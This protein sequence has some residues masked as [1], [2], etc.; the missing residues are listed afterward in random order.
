MVNLDI[1]PAINLISQTLATFDAFSL[2]PG[3]DVKAVTAQAQSLPHHSWEF[4]TAAEAF[5]ELYNPDLSVFGTPFPVP[6]LNISAVPGLSYASQ[7]V[8]FGTGYSALSKGDGSSGDPASLG[9]SAVMIGKADPT[10]AQAADATVQGLLNDVPRFS[11]GAISHRANVPE[12][13]YVITAVLLSS[14]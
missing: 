9:V 1:I 12:L 14:A 3:Y 8:V 5:L 4:G 11:N 13:W 6:T 7:K 10:F 2:S